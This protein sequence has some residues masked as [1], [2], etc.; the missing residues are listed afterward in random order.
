MMNMIVQ[1]EKEE[2]GRQLSMI[3]GRSTCIASISI[4]RRERYL[5]M[6]HSVAREGKK[7]IRL[8]DVS[9]MPIGGGYLCIDHNK[10]NEMKF[11]C[12]RAEC[13]IMGSLR[14]QDPDGRV[15]Y[16]KVP[17]REWIMVSANARYLSGLRPPVQGG[18]VQS[19]TRSK[20]YQQD[21][22]PKRIFF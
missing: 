6:I 13:V 19:A 15:E 18:I 16:S 1:K 2:G 17:L 20:Q 22:S 9:S 7:I 5:I 4:R 11:N 3:V 21:Q 12:A 10:G 8:V 14:L